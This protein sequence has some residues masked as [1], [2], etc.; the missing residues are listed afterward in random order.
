MQIGIHLKKHY[1]APIRAMIFFV[2]HK[3]QGPYLRLLSRCPQ[4]RKT[5][6]RDLI[7]QL[8]Q[9]SLVQYP[10]SLVALP[11]TGNPLL[12]SQ[13]VFAREISLHPFGAVTLHNSDIPC[14]CSIKSTVLF[15]TSVDNGIRTQC[16]SDADRHYCEPAA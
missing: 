11:T 15:T 3:Y 6:P 9:R 7:R 13:S 1:S 16:R 8:H 2:P 4:M 5:R 12:S 14:T 10:P